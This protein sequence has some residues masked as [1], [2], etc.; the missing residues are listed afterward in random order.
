MVKIKDI[1]YGVIKQMERKGSSHKAISAELKI[2]PAT[3]R[4]NLW[5][6]PPSERSRKKRICKRK[7]EIDK[8][9]RL[10]AQLAR[11]TE[12]MIGDGGK[13]GR[14]NRM[15][16]TRKVF[17]SC[18]AIARE[19]FQ[20]KGQVVHYSTV[21]RDFQHMR[22]R[23]LVMQKGPRRMV[24]DREKRVAFCKKYVHYDA[25]RF[26]FSDEHIADTNDHVGRTQWVP[27]GE[28]ADRR[29][30]YP[31]CPKLHV[32]GLIGIGTK[33][34]V[35]FPQGL[36]IDRHEYVRRCLQNNRGTL[37]QSGKLFV[38]DGAKAHTAAETI[39]YLQR[40]GIDVVMDWSPRSPDLNPIELLWSVLQRMVSRRGPTNR[41]ELEKY[42]RESWDA[43]P[44]KY[45]DDL[46][47]GFPDRLQKCMDNDGSTI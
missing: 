28:K 30:Y 3:V 12:K 6:G 47:L 38:Q 11:K 29:E 10:V 25:R 9:R 1:Q 22:Y 37:S 44:Q 46:V 39:Q 21:R 35:I 23:S 4:Y 18:R 17:P 20:I 40:A 41:E 14:A 33:I 13:R 19:Y 43:I 26:L 42:F 31:W 32:W 7:L 8:R 27:P 15:I 5:R 45:V 2:C 36:K 34:L 24:G 16:V